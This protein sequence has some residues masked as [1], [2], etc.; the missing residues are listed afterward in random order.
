[1]V[2]IEMDADGFGAIRHAESTERC[3]F[4]EIKLKCIEATAI[5]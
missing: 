1:M 5:T 2:T 4:S 3:D